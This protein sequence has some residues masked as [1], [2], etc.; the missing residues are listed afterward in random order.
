MYTFDFHGER[1]KLANDEFKGHKLDQYVTCKHRDVC[2][3]GFD[4]DNCVDAV[5]LDLPNP[6]EAIPFA[7]NAL[8]NTG[9]TFEKIMLH[10]LYSLPINSFFFFKL[11]KV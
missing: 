2:A 8:K 9:I 3:I 5:F 4:L 11:T 7:Y 10:S 6:W 1:V